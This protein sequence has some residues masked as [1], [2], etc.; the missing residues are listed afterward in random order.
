MPYDVYSQ[1]GADAKF[2][3]EVD[4]GDP[5]AA[6]LPVTLRRGTTAEWATANPVLAAGEPGTDLDTGVLKVGDGV[7]AWDALPALDPSGIAA[8]VK[9][10]EL[11]AL[12][13]PDGIAD[14]VHPSVVTVPGRWNGYTYWMAV[15]G[16]PEDRENPLVLVSEDGATWTVP[17]GGTNPVFP[18]SWTRAKGY[19][20]NSDTSLTLIGDTMWMLF[21]TV[22]N[23]TLS[24]E[25][26]WLS[27]STDGITWS[28]PATPLWVMNNSDIT[29]RA[30]L[31]PTLVVLPGSGHLAIFTVHAVDGTLAG[32]MTVER[33]VSTDNGVTWGA[34]TT[35][36]TPDL[37]SSSVL[38]SQIWHLEVR[39]HGGQLHLLGQ[40]QSANGV[41]NRLH[42][43]QS[44]DDGAT[45]YGNRS[46]I[47]GSDGS[48]T[49][50]YYR[51]SLQPSLYGS[52]WDLWVTDWTAKRLRYYRN[53]DLSAGAPDLRLGRGIWLPTEHLS[54]SVGGLT[55]LLPSGNARLMGW[56]LAENALGRVTGTIIRPRGWRRMRATLYWINDGAGAGNVY[57]SAV[58]ASYDVGDAPVSLG[59]THDSQ[60]SVRVVAAGAQGV[61]MRTVMSMPGTDSSPGEF[62][63]VLIARDA[64]QATDT[65]ENR[66]LLLGAY[67]EPV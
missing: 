4:G 38:S 15:T 63:V 61:L 31:S 42:Y 43:W 20:Y 47:F 60:G 21:R 41:P 65:L 10:G 44:D 54:T 62:T 55:T 67:I 57:W 66:V 56:R 14:V 29:A 36:T 1:A 46:P 16:M 5:D 28:D 13:T 33:R 22:E 48:E 35:C 3:T 30:S 25:A 26:I 58:F 2:L 45:W 23:V 8:G 17:P 39:A 37:F 53:F 9:S 52:G 18:L 32:A 27:K 11:C 6:P 50:D 51:S 7:A 12:D 34:P 40:A 59:T 49:V 24:R 19:V 64:A